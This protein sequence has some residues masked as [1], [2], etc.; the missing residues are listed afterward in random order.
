MPPY[1]VRPADRQEQAVTGNVIRT[2]LVN[3][4]SCSELMAMLDPLLEAAVGDAFRQQPVHCLT[5]LHGSRVIGASLLDPAPDARAHLFCGPCI[6][7]EYRNR[8][9]GAHL[10][11]RSLEFLQQNGLT[12]AIALTRARSIS[13]RFLYPKF[14]GIGTPL[15]KGEE[16][17]PLTTG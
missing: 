9:L 12:E 7:P 13:A 6:L 15:P 10:L 4:P 1:S 3:D 8:G 14:N 11:A 5:L 17:F 16:A 2:S